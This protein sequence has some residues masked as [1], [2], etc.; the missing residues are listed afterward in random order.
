[1]KIG[2]FFGIGEKG[3]DTVPEQIE[4]LKQA[5]CQIIFGDE[6]GSFLDEQSNLESVFEY[7]RAGDILVI[8]QIF[9]LAPRLRRFVNIGHRLHQ[10]KMGLEILVGE[11][12]QIKPHTPDGEKMMATF[13]AFDQIERE[14][15]SER[16]KKVLAKLKAQ[17]KTLGRRSNFEQ[18][19]PKLIEMQQLGYSAYE[20]SQS[21]GL[22]SRTVKKYLKQLE[23]EI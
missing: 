1:M 4:A 6:I 3:I 20:M 9:C 16:T 11:A 8:W 19:K 5:E 10:Q 18:W 21:T 23:Q 12:S 15:A 14:Y 17:G 2:Y 22:Y 13:S 7:A